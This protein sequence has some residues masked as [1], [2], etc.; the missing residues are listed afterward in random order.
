M[1]DS[2]LEYS[3]LEYSYNNPGSSMK[4]RIYALA[5]AITAMLS[6]CGGG[7]GSSSAAAPASTGPK[8]E[9]LYAG[10]TTS[11]YT[12]NALVLEDDEIWA[13]YGVPSS[14]AFYVYGANWA[15][16]S[17]SNGTYTA[18]NAK[19]YYYTGAVAT[20]TVNA[21][22]VAGSSFNG[23][24]IVNGASVGFTSAAPVSSTYVYTSMASL[25][26]ITGTWTGTTLFGEAGTMVIASNGTLTASF[27]GSYIGSCTATGTVQPRASGKNV[28]DVSIVFGTAPCSLPGTTATGIALSYLLTNG[29]RQLIAAV[30]TSSKANGSAFFAA[31]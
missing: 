4:N 10:T 12:F 21:S 8:A 31:R 23:A 3:K 26:T 18:S 2:I 11:G 13:L 22:Y 29:Q 1:L 9:G 7:G 27:T 17:S 20:G 6:A 24:A 16:G 25:P 14:G 30:T 15:Q 19:D 28:F 5:L